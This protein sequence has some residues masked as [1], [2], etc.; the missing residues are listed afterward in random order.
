LNCP[1][2]VKVCKKCKRILIACEINF[3]KKSS[4]KYGFEGRCKECIRKRRK[5]YEERE[6]VKERRREYRK[7][8]YQREDVKERSKEQAKIYNQREDV[9]ERRKELNQKYMEEHREKRLKYWKEYYEEHKKERKEYYEIYWKNNQA[10]LFD[11]NNKRRQLEESQ[12]NGVT[13]EQWLEM[14]IFFNWCCAYSGEYLGG[15]GN[16]N[17]SIDHI[18]PLSKNGEHNIW[19]CV[20]MFIAYNKKKRNKDML[21]WYKQQEYFL[22][23]RLEKIY[24]WIEYA[25]NKWNKKR[26]K[27][28]KKY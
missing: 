1:Y 7:K 8:Y 14:M 10:K 5:E 17:R 18:I 23:E 22:E 21:D 13:D 9:K 27:G 25:Y 24:A 11:Y 15:K 6:D 12:G 28:N 3:T 2:N 26:R 19:N 16:E 20:P 4:G